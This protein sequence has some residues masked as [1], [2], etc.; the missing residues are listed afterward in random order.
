MTATL[1]MPA[2]EPSPDVEPVHPDPEP[3]STLPKST[4]INLD[5]G[6]DEEK[7]PSVTPQLSVTQTLT[8]TAK[9]SSKVAKEEVGLYILYGTCSIIISILSCPRLTLNMRMKLLTVLTSPVGHSH[10]K[11]S[12]KLHL[13]TKFNSKSC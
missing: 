7:E 9:A 1:E 12:L 13:I 2:P 11:L 3:T 5:N 10:V 4:P 6:L 8:S